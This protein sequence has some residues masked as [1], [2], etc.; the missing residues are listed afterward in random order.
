MLTSRPA[1]IK[2]EILLNLSG[3]TPLK[4][5][6]DKSFSGYFDKIWRELTNEK[7]ETKNS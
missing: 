7:S 1:K 3:E 2:D 6:E 5:R 4:K